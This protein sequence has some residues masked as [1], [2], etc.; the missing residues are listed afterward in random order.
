MS[1][2]KRAAGQVRLAPVVGVVIRG[3]GAEDAG[4]SVMAEGQRVVGGVAARECVVVTATG[5]QAFHRHPETSHSLST[6]SEP[7]KERQFMRERKIR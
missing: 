3:G 2:G 5:G 6:H 4:V 1:P 7:T